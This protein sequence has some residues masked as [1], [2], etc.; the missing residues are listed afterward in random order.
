LFEI[1]PVVGVAEGPT[2]ILAYWYKERGGQ[3][4]HVVKA[5]HIMFGIKLQVISKK[6][7]GY[8]VFTFA[9][10]LCVGRSVCPSV[11]LSQNIIQQ[12]PISCYKYGLVWYTENFFS[13][14]HFQY[15]REAVILENIQ[16]VI[17]P[18]P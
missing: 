1:K 5:R 3:K 10:R 4:C 17:S 18:E 16:W 15:G 2:P 13:L 12:S 8:I 14:P 11:S 6:V 7:C 9:V